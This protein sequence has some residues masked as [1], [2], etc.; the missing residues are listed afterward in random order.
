MKLPRRGFLH[1]AA[2]VAAVPVIFAIVTGLSGSA[3]SQ[4]ARTIKIVVP[5]AAGGP[6]DTLARVVAE[7]IGRAHGLTMAVENRAGGGTVIG[8]E[9]VSRAAPDGNTLLINSS[10][11]VIS[12]HFRKLNYNPLTGFEPICYL[13][14]SQMVV[15]VNSASPYRT[16]A[17]LLD[18]ARAKPG[19][20]TLANSGAAGITHIASEMLKGVTKTNITGVPYPGGAPAVNA[21]LGDHVRSALLDYAVLAEQLKASKLR[22]LATTSGVRIESLPDVPTVA[23][24]GYKDFAVDIWYGVFAPAKTPKEM[25]SQLAGWFTSALEAPDIRAKLA[26]QGVYPVG[27]CGA[28]FSAFLR[29]QYE[30]FGSV[31]REAHIKAE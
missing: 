29:K 3:R 6:A 4:T 25:V 5:F 9:A 26:I 7:Q 13:V 27:M 2:G 14:R 22:A 1:L 15:V 10:S 17:D 18:A 8:T 11:I 12:P 31:I 28:E 30:E 20:L 19:D 24:S 21:L 23:E 16:L